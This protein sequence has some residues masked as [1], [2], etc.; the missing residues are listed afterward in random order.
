MCL[1][2]SLA[3]DDNNDKRICLVIVSVALGLHSVVRLRTS[4]LGVGATL[5]CKSDIL[6]LNIMTIDFT[7]NVPH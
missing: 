2:R 1:Y 7:G 6:E 5:Q 4:V 3:F